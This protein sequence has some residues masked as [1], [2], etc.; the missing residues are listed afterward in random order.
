[1]D[2]EIDSSLKKI[3]LL[4]NELRHRTEDCQQLVGEVKI[5][6]KKIEILEA[7]AK[8]REHESKFNSTQ[9]KQ[10]LLKMIE[11]IKSSVL[12]VQTE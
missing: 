12:D 3:D 9:E 10:K 1:M 8:E 6:K 7:N 11:Q 2:S 5:L 4:Q